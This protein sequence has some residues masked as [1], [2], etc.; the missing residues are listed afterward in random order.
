MD[1]NNKPLAF[2]AT[3]ANFKNVQSRKVLQVILEVPIEQATQVFD[4]LGMPN[5][6]A[7]TW[8]AVARLIPEKEGDSNDIALSVTKE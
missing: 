6:H 8:V 4:A 5:A 7:S 1:Q 2:Q 3:Y